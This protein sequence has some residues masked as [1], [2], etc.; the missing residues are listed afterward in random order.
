MGRRS[1]SFV[2]LRCVRSA[3]LALFLSLGGA[4]ACAEPMAPE[5]R[6]LLDVVN[7]KEPSDTTNDPTWRLS[8]AR[9]LHRYCES[10]LVQ[11]PRNTPQED[12]WVDGE[13]Q[14]AAKSTD[15]LADA[16]R[17]IQELKRM[18]V[19][20]NRVFNSPEYARKWIRKVLSDCSSIAK[21]LIEPDKRLPAAEALLWVRLSRLFWFE[22]EMWRLAKIVGLVS[23]DGCQKYV[24][25]ASNLGNDLAGIVKGDAPQTRDDGDRYNLCFLRSVEISIVDHAVV[26]LLEA[27]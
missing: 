15:P 25:G 26:P 22:D 20:Q 2:G 3:A 24:Q 9:A 7:A 5:I 6:S 13:L 18:E 12:R 1:L 11:V 27:R 17:W 23:G 10:A 19:R 14:D 4:L 8:L 16:E 21:A